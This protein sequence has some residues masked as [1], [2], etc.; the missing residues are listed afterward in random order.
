M[1]VILLCV[2]ISVNAQE[3]LYIHQTDGTENYFKIDEIEEVNFDKTSISVL[4]IPPS[5][6]TI[7]H[8]G[9]E[10]VDIGLSVKWASCNIG[11]LEPEGRGD[12]YA[13]G[14]S[15]TK[16]KYTIENSKYYNTSY[17]D[18]LNGKHIINSQDHLEFDYDVATIKWGKGWRCPSAAEMKELISLQCKWEYVVINNQECAKIT[19]PNGNHIILP[20]AGYYE[21]SNL[22]YA[23]DDYI[24]TN[25]ACYWS[26]DIYFIRSDLDYE[27]DSF[28][29]SCEFN[30]ID[31][32]EYKVGSRRRYFGCPIRPVCVIK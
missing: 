15:R 14:E 11:A 22:L 30:N 29:L 6:E 24:S 20:L 7:I 17:E 32:L 27:K 25:K 1:F 23:D 31:R 5:A 16:S 12:Y 18:L 2:N 8:N 28:S 13:W 10:A 21:D 3:Y 9:H 19:G 26:S 4:P